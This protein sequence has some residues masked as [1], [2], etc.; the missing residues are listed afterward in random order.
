MRKTLLTVVLVFG[1]MLGTSMSWGQS[2]LP[3]ALIGTP[4]VYQDYFVFNK[5][6]NMNVAYWFVDIHE[7]IQ[8]NDSTTDT[9][10]DKRVRITDRN[11][12]KLDSSYQNRPL[13]VEIKGF[14]SA[15]TLIAYDEWDWLPI[16]VGL[17]YW[18]G[19]CKATCV[20]PT[21]AY[22]ISILAQY[23]YNTNNRTSLNLH[24]VAG[25]DHTLS[26]GNFGSNPVV[27]W[28]NFTNVNKATFCG[29]GSTPAYNNPSNIYTN[30]YAP[31]HH[32]FNWCPDAIPFGQWDG[33]NFSFIPGNLNNGFTYHEYDGTVIG[34][35][36]D[37]WRVAKGWGKWGEFSDNLY[38]GTLALFDN[39]ILD[40]PEYECAQMPQNGSI[41]GSALL[42]VWNPLF[43]PLLQKEVNSQ[44]VTVPLE[45][46]QM[47]QGS[48]GSGGSGG[49]SG[50]QRP[51]VRT[52]SYTGFLHVKHNK[53]I[54]GG[55]NPIFETLADLQTINLNEFDGTNTT[56]IPWWP[57]DDVALIQIYK[58]DQNP[59]ILN[60]EPINL[61][62]SLLIDSSGN[63]TPF[64]FILQKGLYNLVLLDEEYNSFRFLFE[65]DNN[66]EHSIQKADFVDVNI[67][68][69]PIDESKQQITTRVNPLI[70]TNYTYTIVDVNNNQYYASFGSL[71]QNDEV[72]III[73]T[74]N[75][76]SGQLF[77]RFVFDDGSIIILQTL[78]N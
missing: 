48:G 31:K 64:N 3:N 2:S 41:W 36:G 52:V 27:F 50:W 14:N 40:S 20:A 34:A 16:P 28:R 70:N 68:P 43:E 42:S 13:H 7:V 56:G 18:K 5:F 39:G 63:L 78:K 6:G 76:P 22:N 73:Q 77:H 15:N 75:L 35:S 33:V 11:F 51:W 59:D 46:Q 29:N 24:H 72:D 62:P 44:M 30:I 66:I 26:S 74:E 37:V 10:F 71:Y 60:F 55:T 53:P 61:S 32:G 23:E 69:N 49:G 19:L 57:G 65:L 67:F 38:T 4:D 8:I 1:V 54:S 21:Y 9:R 17:P 47:A 12:Y 45:C 58:I 25:G